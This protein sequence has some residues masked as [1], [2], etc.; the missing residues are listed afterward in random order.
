VLFTSSSQPQTESIL[1]V[2]FNSDRSL[3][4]LHIKNCPRD[5]Q[6][7]HHNWEIFTMATF[8]IK[9]PFTYLMSCAFPREDSCLYTTCFLHASGLVGK[10]NIQVMVMMAMLLMKMI[11]MMVMMMMMMMAMLLLLLMMMMM[12]MVRM[13]VGMILM[14]RMMVMMMVMV[15]MMM[16]MMLMMVIYARCC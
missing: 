4:T 7:C 1:L 11:M 14:V 15:M 8:A 10:E 12:M 3:K 5:P 13:M 9:Q 6:T 16:M 2:K